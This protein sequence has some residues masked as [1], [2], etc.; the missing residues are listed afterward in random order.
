MWQYNNGRVARTLFDRHVWRI[1]MSRISTAIL[2]LFVGSLL[3]TP[4]LAQDATTFRFKAKP[5]DK[6][7]YQISSTV[8]MSQKIGGQDLTTKIASKQSIEREV[9]KSDKD[10]IVALRARSLRLQL[11]SEFPGG[12]EYKFD[13]DSTDNND[14][15][16]I[17]AAL[18][19]LYDA[20]NG[21]IV[22]L[23]LTP[24]GKVT[25]ATGLAE[26]I[27]GAIQDNAIAQ[28]F[29]AGADSDEGVA[30]AMQDQ[31]IE[32][33][34]KA[35]SPGDE[36]E[37]PYDMTLP[38]LGTTTSTTK[39]KYEG[40]DEDSGQGKSIHKFTFTTSMDFDIDLKS[41]QFTATGKLKISNSSGT[42]LFDA[43]AG[44]LVSKKSETTLG[45]DITIEAGGN[46]VPIQQEQ[47]QKME[48]KLL[49]GPPKKDE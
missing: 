48:L 17:G 33:P 8:D 41:D 49:D 40:L 43:E 15:S 42:A 14:G 18:G 22:E 5:G 28:Q 30:H 39:Y 32:F 7:Y 36:W 35:L 3:T 45:G 12:I 16:Q 4:L 21:A 26:A 1:I 47:N 24:Q 25:K 23:T 44:R 13:S 9:T 10:G 37:V 31:F 2:A 29:A 11:N 46:T 34:K 20:I 27:K 38:K 6:R 19:P